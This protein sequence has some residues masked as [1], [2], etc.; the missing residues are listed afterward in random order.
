MLYLVPTSI[1]LFHDLRK[2]ANRRQPPSYDLFHVSVLLWQTDVCTDEYKS[3]VKIS[4]GIHGLMPF[5]IQSYE[6]CIKGQ[7]RMIF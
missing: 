5:L 3:F 2:P 6:Y 4:G 7:N 1:T